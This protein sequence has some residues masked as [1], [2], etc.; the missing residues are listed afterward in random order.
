MAGGYQAEKDQLS[1][2][3]DAIRDLQRRVTVLEQRSG[4]GDDLDQPDTG[5]LLPFEASEQVA[6]PAGTV[7]VL[8]KALLGIAGAYLLR[9]LA[10]SGSVATYI[11]VPVAL[12]YAFTWLVGAT[13][14]ATPSSLATATYGITAALILSP[15]L[16]ETTV[17]FRAIPSTAAAAALATF[18]ILSL[19]LAWTRNATA[20]IWIST[21]TALM[22][23][24][25][26]ILATHDVVPFVLA[27]VLISVAVEYAAC[28]HRWLA[29]RWIVAATADLAVVLVAYL[30]TR[31][32]G[33]PEGYTPIPPGV[34]VALP[35]L[36]AAT[37]VGSWMYRTCIRSTGVTAFEVLQTASVL[38]IACTTLLQVVSGPYATAVKVA[39]LVAGAA[40][41]LVAFNIF[42]P[43]PGARPTMMTY[44]TFG[45]LLVCSGAFLLSTDA[46]IGAA[47]LLLCFFGWMMRNEVLNAHAAVSATLAIVASGSFQYCVHR[48]LEPSGAPVTWTVM[49]NGAVAVAIYAVLKLR[50]PE[51]RAS[52]VPVTIAGAA[53]YIAAVGAAA[54]AV[55]SLPGVSG[56]PALFS[57]LATAVV[58]GSVLMLVWAAARWDRPEAKWIGWGVMIA[59]GVKLLLRDF[60]AAHALSLFASLVVYGGTLILL[61]R[62][63]K[64]HKDPPRSASA[65]A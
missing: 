31:P 14:V 9:A 57:S 49:F 22:T 52:N 58:A 23:C 30:V 34:V 41:Y 60:P 51:E 16:W 45:C 1:Q 21:I 38:A 5:S 50:P 64:T 17:R 11:A 29:L 40:A 37:Y 6:L 20:I 26:L 59:W 32:H 4:A 3:I 7:A 12:V 8:G 47:A 2:L 28:R 10:E 42:A 13:R 65:G 35:L 19:W 62:A 48:L 27:A 46:A 43:R 24:W 53:A 61:S 55:S 36:L 56:A 39:C 25:A 33:L 18:L 15:M 63:T 54:T 44:A